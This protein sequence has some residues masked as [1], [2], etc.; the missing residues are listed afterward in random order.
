MYTNAPKHEIID[1]IPEII[2]QNQEVQEEFIWNNKKKSGHTHTTYVLF[3]SLIWQLNNSLGN[4]DIQ[5]N[6]P[7]LNTLQK[8]HIYRIQTIH[9]PITDT[10]YYYDVYWRFYYIRYPPDDSTNSAHTKLHSTF[11]ST[12]FEFIY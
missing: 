11:S 1:M 4:L 6:G 8:Y 5:I 3:G 7:N 10:Y 9:H 2:S 12:N